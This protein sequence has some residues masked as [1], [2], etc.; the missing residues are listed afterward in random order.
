MQ[1][2]P[3]E[4]L[5]VPVYNGPISEY[6]PPNT[7]YFQPPCRYIFHG[8]EV[9][10]SPDFADEPNSLNFSSDSESSESDNDN[11][12]EN[13]VTSLGN[14]HT[15]NFALSPPTDNDQTDHFLSSEHILNPSHPLNIPSYLTQDIIEQYLNQ[16]QNLSEEDR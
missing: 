14:N 16:Q 8:A 4:Q 13:D 11:E 3:N 5:N 1:S 7:Y 10:Y 15:N 2:P 12:N 6:L 9:A